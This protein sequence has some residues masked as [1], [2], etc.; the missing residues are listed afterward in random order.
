MGPESEKVDLGRGLTGS[1]AARL[2]GSP[3][4]RNAPAIGI[5]LVYGVASI[6]WLAAGP[7]SPG[8]RWSS[9]RWAS[10]SSSP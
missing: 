2:R 8:G 7:A 5:A 4:A 3:F 10:W 9:G 1:D 6:V